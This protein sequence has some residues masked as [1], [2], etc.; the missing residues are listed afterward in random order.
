MA[1]ALVMIYVL[2][3]LIPLYVSALSIKCLQ[4]SLV[5]GL[6]VVASMISDNSVNETG[7]KNDGSC[8]LEHCPPARSVR[9]N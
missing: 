7:K 4:S 9:P 6:S 8:G 5:K 1:S 3:G 2:F